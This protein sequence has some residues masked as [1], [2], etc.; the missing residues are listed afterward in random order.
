MPHFM[1]VK[2]KLLAFID[3][4]PIFDSGC[5]IRSLTQEAPFVRLYH[6]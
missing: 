6:M 1:S 5:L 4:V 3:I 2:L